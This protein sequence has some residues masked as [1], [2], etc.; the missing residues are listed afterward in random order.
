MSLHRKYYFETT[1][2][3]KAHFFMLYFKLCELLWHGLIS[4]T[5]L[6]VPIMHYCLSCQLCHGWQKDK[7]NYFSTHKQAR[8]L[9]SANVDNRCIE[10][11]DLMI[12]NLCCQ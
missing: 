7:G 8:A 9:L 6:C 5:T 12:K 2:P 4:N 10:L 1:I 3:I 11:T